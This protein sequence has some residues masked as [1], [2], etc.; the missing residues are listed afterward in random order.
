MLKNHSTTKTMEKDRPTTSSHNKNNDESTEEEIIE[1][2]SIAEEFS[3]S[4]DEIPIFLNEDSDFGN[5]KRQLFDIDDDK[6]F[7]GDVD[8][9]LSLDNIAKHFKPLLENDP[10]EVKENI[11][12]SNSDKN[13]R[14]EKLQKQAKNKNEKELSPLNDD[15]ILINDRKVSLSALKKVQIATSVPATESSEN[16]RQFASLNFPKVPAA[17]SL[18]TSHSLDLDLSLG[19]SDD[20][21]NDSVENENSI[22]EMIE[23]NEYRSEMSEGSESDDKK[24]SP[25]KMLPQRIEE[26]QEVVVVKKMEKV[27]PDYLKEPLDDITEEESEAESKEHP[28]PGAKTS[29]MER[30]SQMRAIL[31]HS[32]VAS[33]SL[34]EPPTFAQSHSLDLSNKSLKEL[35]DIVIEKDSCLDALNLQLTSLAR[36]ENFKDGNGRESLKESAPYSIATSAS[37][38]YRT[39]N[40]DFNLKILD[41]E[42]ELHDRAVCIDQL[43]ERLQQSVLEREQFQLQSVELAREVL[44]LKTKV[45]GIESL[46][47]SDEDKTVISA[48]RISDFKKSLPEEE[49]ACFGKVWTKFESFHKSEIDQLKLVHD[50]EMKKFQENIDASRRQADDEINRWKQL[51]EKVKSSSPEVE[52]LRKE[53]EAKHS[54]EMEELREY[55]EKRCVDMEKQYSEDVFSQHSKRVEGNET[56]GSDNETLPDDEA[57]VHE[58]PK[59]ISKEAS[60]HRRS[61]METSAL[62][63]VIVDDDATRVELEEVKQMFAEKIR[64]INLKH[65]EVVESLK[66]KLKQYE[67]KFEPSEEFSVSARFFFLILRQVDAA[68]SLQFKASLH[69]PFKCLNFCD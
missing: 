63:N 58:S 44:Q 57:Q 7:L 35:Q 12:P 66:M 48:P 34:D 50:G 13:F 59:R 21:L 49:A 65:E 33:K 29:I 10:E 46:R 9:N 38:E 53:L 20:S 36:R 47:S 41:I 67:S 30:G 55:F 56:D 27:T 8:K 17:V 15:V 14:S 24:A 4:D 31:E 1:D 37:T 52:E 6:F 40:E 43:K 25:A 61:L 16:N 42:N 51:L 26:K 3:D 2:I 68:V 64:E 69:Q 54:K 45:A 39:I 19:N 28:V 60:L 62:S 5:K 22:D 23:H 18:R 11:V 32:L